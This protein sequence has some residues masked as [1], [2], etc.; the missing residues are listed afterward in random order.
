[1]QKN[2]MAQ[3]AKT[4]K[5]KKKHII[6]KEDCK[7]LAIAHYQLYRAMF[8]KGLLSGMSIGA[9]SH[10]AFQFIK[11]KLSTMDKNNPVTKFLIRVN[12]HL[13]KR[14]TKR[15]MTSRNRDDHVVFIP[16]EQKKILVK[17]PQ[18]TTKSLT[19]FN[20]LSAKYKPKQKIVAKPAQQTK[21][22]PTVK[23][24]KNKLLGITTIAGVLI[25]H[26]RENV[27]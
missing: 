21:D 7:K 11:A 27:K 23:E 1:M 13:S 10:N 25:Q 17:I 9:A 4:Q 8:L 20:T 3:V 22:L 16:Q 24:Y 18:W 19:V 2:N 6:S 26:Q 15:V 14:I 12:K 5:T